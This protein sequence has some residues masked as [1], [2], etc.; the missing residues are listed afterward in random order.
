VS[1]EAAIV[2]AGRVAQA[3][4]R[5]LRER[6]EPVVAV[7]S[8]NGEHAA[9]A[10]AF[11]GV[12]AVPLAAIPS[13]AGRIVIA[14]ADDAIEE[15]ASSLAAAGF[16][17]GL[18]LHTC[19]AR[20]PESLE[21]LSSQG[22]GC[23]VLHPL[24]T[25][26]SPEQ[27]L[28]ALPGAAF[29]VAGAPAAVEWA[30][31]LVGLLGGTALQI[32]PERMPLYHAAAVLA[33]NAVIGLVDAAAIL[34][35]SAGL[36]ERQA[37]RALGGILRAS[38]ENAIAMSP[39]AALTGPIQRGDIETVRRHLRA[40]ADSPPSVSGLYRAA[41]RHLVAVARRRG[42]AEDKARRIEELLE[43]GG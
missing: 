33:S 16:R 1:A 6:G 31:G 9:A 22:A 43:R 42:L 17:G 7:A 30:R 36:D 29:G 4:G 20:G 32:A 40:L 26:A 41:G 3:L 8:R 21:E 10:A 28:E 23:G 5:L 38:A 15:V 12:E 39:T 2:G 35:V 13:R 19:G 24:Q 34:M 27:G 18:A 11:I 14:V 37:I 25:I